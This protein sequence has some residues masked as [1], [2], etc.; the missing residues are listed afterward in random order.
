MKEVIEQ[1]L[2]NE[3][4]RK[5][6][7]IVHM[8]LPQKLYCSLHHPILTL[9]KNM[10]TKQNAVLFNPRSPLVNPTTETNAVFIA[11]C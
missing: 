8:I 1:K 2:E 9:Y 11:Q 7:C 4:V 10:D 3:N 5:K 6:Q